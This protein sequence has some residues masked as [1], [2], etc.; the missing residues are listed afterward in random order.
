[1]RGK[2]HLNIEGSE[3]ILHS[4]ETSY[5]A[6]FLYWNDWKEFEYSAL[7]PSLIRMSHCFLDVG[8]NFG[9]Y[10]LL[11]SAINKECKIISFEP[12][13]GPM[14]YLKLNI[15][16]NRLSSQ[17]TPEKYAVSSSNKSL[18]F[19][20]SRNEKYSYIQYDLSSIGRIEPNSSN[21]DHYHVDCIT[22]D[23]YCMTNNIRPDLLKIDVEGHEEQVFYGANKIIEQNR[24]S[25]ICEVL[26]SANNHFIETFMERNNYLCYD[27]SSGKPKKI[28]RLNELNSKSDILLISANYLPEFLN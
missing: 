14:H 8:A 20:E 5:L 13:N 15:N 24:P 27:I 7:F 4:N 21:V 10:S 6:R 25:I 12:S 17:I 16:E 3:L 1:M 9:Y 18:I 19:T 22:L 11:A 26:P 23:E 2:F 28:M